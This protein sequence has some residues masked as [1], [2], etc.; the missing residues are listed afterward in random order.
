MS[1]RRAL[2]VSP[3]SQHTSTERPSTSAKRALRTGRQWIS[4]EG[5]L[6][7]KTSVARLDTRVDD[8]DTLVVSDERALHRV[9]REPLDIRESQSSDTRQAL[10]FVG[11]RDIRH[12]PVVRVHSDAKALRDEVPDGMLRKRRYSAGIHVRRRTEL[13][14][15]PFVADVLGERSELDNLAFADRHVLDEPHAVTDPMRAA[16]LQRLPDRRRP[17]RFAGVDGDRKVLAAAE[18]ERL[19]MGLRRMSGFLAGDVET[20]DASLAVRHGELGHLE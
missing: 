18:L 3:G 7:T 6:P 13:Q 12:E 19:D 20:D 10:E 5:A 11:E 2:F 14:R 15:D 17:E 8:R 9:D 1:R 4:G 16:V